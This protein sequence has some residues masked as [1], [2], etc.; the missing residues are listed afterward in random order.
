MNVN[1]IVKKLEDEI[2]GENREDVI[3]SIE[4]VLSQNI[5][6]LSKNENFY[7]LSLKQIFSVVSKVNFNDIEQNDEIVE[8]V[9]IIKNIIK[10]IQ[11]T[12]FEE[13]ETILILQNININT[14]EISF[15]YDE[16]ISILELITNCPLLVNLCQLYREQTK[17]V[18][19]DYDYELEQKSKEI[20]TLKTELET[21]KQPKVKSENTTTPQ[22]F[23]KHKDNDKPITDSLKF[24]II[25][26]SK[27]GKSNILSRL[28]DNSFYPESQPTVG[29]EFDSTVLA[30]DEKRVKLQIWDTYG[31]E[32]FRSIS[33]A[34]FRNSK[35]ALLVYD[36]TSRKSF[37]NIQQWMV[38]LKSL[39][40]DCVMILVG[41]KSDLENER[42]VS[43]EEG[44]KF[45][46]QNHMLFIETSAKAGTNIEE[47]FGQITKNCLYK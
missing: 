7:K 16:I 45:A 18:Y 4:E 40:E 44:S 13:K 42:V 31:Q 37:E 35:C 19:I 27:V 20:E 12:H 9:E 29:I 28:V 21:L 23:S 38:D 10:N 26:D 43:Q 34:Y 32:L 17:E 14:T 24:V 1:E 41:N 2:N 5:K 36:I 22:N 46:Q 6:E 11:E 47:A 15:S 25:G 3:D 8:V 39:S 33:K 30:N